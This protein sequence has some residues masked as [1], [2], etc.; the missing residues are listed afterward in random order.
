MMCDR[1]RIGIKDGFRRMRYGLMMDRH[2]HGTH[3]VGLFWNGRARLSM[4]RFY[5]GTKI[6]RVGKGAWNNFQGR[7]KRDV[8]LWGK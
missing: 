8:Y 6:I 1:I 7:W 3:F 5:D 4:M 2:Y